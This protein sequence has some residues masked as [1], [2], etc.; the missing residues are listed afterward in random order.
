M[1]NVRKESVSR[2]RSPEEAI[3]HSEGGVRASLPEGI[4]QEDLAKVWRLLRRTKPHLYVVLKAWVEGLRLR[5]DRTRYS[6][7][8]YR[9][10]YADLS[11]RLGI[12]QN[13]VK[14]RLQTAIKWFAERLEKERST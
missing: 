1:A 11:R 5:D 13:A 4:R 2:E 3:F 8:L 7:G 14:Y 6:S 10:F 12:T 9:G